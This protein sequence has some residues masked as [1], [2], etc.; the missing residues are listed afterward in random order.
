[1]EDRGWRMEEELENY[2]LFIIC[3]LRFAIFYLAV[4]P[5]VDFNSQIANRK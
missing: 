2:L 5:A 1:M 3:D 4:L